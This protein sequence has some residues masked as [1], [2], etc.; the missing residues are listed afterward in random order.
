MFDNAPLFLNKY[1]IM[2][3]QPL[4]QIQAFDILLVMLDDRVRLLHCGFY[5]YIAHPSILHPKGQ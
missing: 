3:Y 1:P 5:E 4:Y 2:P